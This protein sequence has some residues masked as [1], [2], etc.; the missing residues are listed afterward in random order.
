M[1]CEICY[2]IGRTQITHLLQGQDPLH[3]QKNKTNPPEPPKAV[4]ET[5][6]HDDDNKSQ[7]RS[8][9]KTCKE[10][11]FV[12]LLV[13]LQRNSAVPAYCIHVSRGFKPS[14]ARAHLCLCEPFSMLLFFCC[15]KHTRG[16]F[17]S[18]WVAATIFMKKSHQR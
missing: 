4:P 14:R 13:V 2:L 15:F 16:I 10:P 6:L 9:L 8:K 11:F 7:V 17:A 12:K 1:V 5:Q 18:C 3:H